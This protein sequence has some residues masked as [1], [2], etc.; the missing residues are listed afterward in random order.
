[1]QVVPGAGGGDEFDYD[2]DW[3]GDWDIDRSLLDDDDEGGIAFEG[4]ED[5][6]EVDA[7]AL[8]VVPASDE[9]VTELTKNWVQAGEK[10]KRQTARGQYF[11]CW[12]G[13]SCLS[14]AV[15]SMPAFCSPLLFF[16]FFS[17]FLCLSFLLSF[18]FLFF[19]AIC[20]VGVCSAFRIRHVR[21][22]IGESLTTRKDQMD[23][24]LDHHAQIR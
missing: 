24:D 2:P 22:C 14:T 3:D 17:F 11:I 20:L 19:P 10:D 15:Y 16:V 18:C 4:E 8:S 1:M 6:V 23:H 9:E 5:G 12:G 13:G 21:R 7:K